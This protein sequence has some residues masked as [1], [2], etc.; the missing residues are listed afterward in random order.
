MLVYYFVP[1]IVNNH[2]LLSF[3]WSKLRNHPKSDTCLC[4]LFWSQRPRKS[5]P[6]VLSTSRETLCIQQ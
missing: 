3:K 2:Y 1:F 4:E 6:A 5:P